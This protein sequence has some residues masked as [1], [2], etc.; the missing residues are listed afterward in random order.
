MKACA[1]AQ[2]MLRTTKEGN[3]S[4]AKNGTPEI[5]NTDHGTQFTSG[6]WIGVLSD[7]KIKIS[8]NGKGR[9]IAT[10]IARNPDR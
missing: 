9:R 7:A 8:V 6:V 5:L 3:R 2:W 1:A 10:L 4:E